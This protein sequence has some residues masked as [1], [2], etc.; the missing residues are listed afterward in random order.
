[1]A[2]LTE[3]DPNLA[4]YYGRCTNCDARGIDCAYG[5]RA[6]WDPC[7]D[8]CGHHTGLAAYIRNRRQT[9]GYTQRDL[10]QAVG[11]TDSWVSMIERRALILSSVG[12]L[13]R[14]GRVLG[15]DLVTFRRNP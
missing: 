15:V 5:L 6:G 4:H 11:R 3:T 7:C 1:M 13:D 14:V 9:L 2:P 12:E 8:D 10:A